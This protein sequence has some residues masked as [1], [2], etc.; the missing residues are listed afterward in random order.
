M[1]ANL[2]IYSFLSTV[3]V[4]TV[5]CSFFLDVFVYTA[6]VSEQNVLG[7]G[8]SHEILLEV[9]EGTNNY[10]VHGKFVSNR[11]SLT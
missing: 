4:L 3:I 11:C 8:G 7:G 1:F 9:I 2:C 10:R 6:I 5:L